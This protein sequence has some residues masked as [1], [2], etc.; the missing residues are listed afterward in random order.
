MEYSTLD[1]PIFKGKDKQVKKHADAEV[2]K[3]YHYHTKT[4]L[5]IDPFTGF[6][7]NDN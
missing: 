7:N 2:N 3:K 5:E 6:F 1:S 4:V